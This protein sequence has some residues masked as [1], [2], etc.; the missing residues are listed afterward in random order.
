MN[1]TEGSGERGARSGTWHIYFRYGEVLLNAAE[2][3]FELNKLDEAVGYINQLRTRAGFTIP[4]TAADVTFD[5]IVNERRVELAFE[6]YTLWD[7]K[8]WR[9]AHIVWYRVSEDLTDTPGIA[10]ARSNRP[11]GLW[12]YRVHDPNG[13]MDN[14]YIFKE[15]LPSRVTA[16]D[17]FRMGNYYSSISDGIINNNPQIVRNPNQN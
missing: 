3:A 10:T 17:E 12:P 4:L 1:L 13:P 7:N 5:R 11:F 14:K 16:A 8:R 2:A 15:V 6:G 9:I